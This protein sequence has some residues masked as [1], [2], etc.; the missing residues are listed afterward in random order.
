MNK[1][2][3]EDILASDKYK[4]NKDLINALIKKD[5]LLALKQINDRI[6]KYKERKI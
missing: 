1:Y 3:K 5:E 6:K 4:H 2:S